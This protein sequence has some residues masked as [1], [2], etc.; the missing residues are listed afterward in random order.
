VLFVVAVA[1]AGCGGG[2]DSARSQAVTDAIQR[3]IADVEDFDVSDCRDT[4]ET[5]SEAN[6]GDTLEIWRCS[7]NSPNGAGSYSSGNESCWA[8]PLQ[9]RKTS[10]FAQLDECP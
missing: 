5:I 7:K 4:G 8:V 6:T 10:S 2:D 3:I 9:L 1:V